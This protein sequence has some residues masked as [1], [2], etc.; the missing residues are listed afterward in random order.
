M[1]Y[2]KKQNMT[3]NDRKVLYAQ[4]H[5]NLWNFSSKTFFILHLNLYLSKLNHDCI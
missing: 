1:Y 2:I 5:Y 4:V 3:V